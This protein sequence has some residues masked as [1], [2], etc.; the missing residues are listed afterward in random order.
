MLAPHPAGSISSAAWI[1]L[2]DPTA[3]EIEQVRAATG[4]RV[5]SRHEIDEIQS[6]SRLA[7]ESGAYYL[8][9]PIGVGASIGFVLS[10]KFLLTVRFVEL[11]EL[12]AARETCSARK[13]DSAEE[14][15]LVILERFVDRCA[16]ELERAGAECDEL[17]HHA[18]R[19]STN[20]RG[21]HPKGKAMS[22]HLRRI[23]AV[24]DHASRIRDSLLGFG[25]IGTFLLESAIP[26]A[27]RL[28]ANR[29][30]AIRDDVASLADYQSHLAGK[31][32][33]LLD[34]TLGFINIEQN[35]IVKTLTVASLV[36]IPP[37]LVA[38]IYGMNFH[39]MPELS[40]T[41]GY[42]FALVVIAVS[43]LVPLVWFRQRGWL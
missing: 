40:W 2:F 3:E 33:F 37:V 22:A 28:S 15:F 9:A 8:S 24:A 21:S 26:H 6:T 41:W 17:S 39:V 35:E 5:P 23:G 11:P 20:R 43:A 27:P 10:S 36:G 16:D 29:L 30:K 42:P 13:A 19:A 34:A 18:F 12:G 1:D 4:L 25:R 7:F 31:L 38:G 14:S 32:Q